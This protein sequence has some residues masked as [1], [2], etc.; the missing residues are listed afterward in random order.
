MGETPDFRAKRYIEIGGYSDLPTVAEDADFEETTS[1]TDHEATLQ[2]SKKG[3]IDRITR[4]MII[5][6]D[7][8]AVARIPK[9]MAAAAKRTLYKAV[10]N[11]IINNSNIYDGTPLYTLAHENLITDALNEDGVALGKARQKLKDMKEKDN[12]EKLGIRGKYLIIPSTQAMT[13]TAYKLTTGAFGSVNNIPKI[14]QTWGIEPIEVVTWNSQTNW[15]LMADPNEN[16]TVQ[17]DF[18]QG[19]QEPELFIQDQIT[20]D[21]FFVKER[22]RYKIRHEYGIAVLSFKT[23]VGAE[24][25]A[26]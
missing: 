12:A 9:K 22:I 24:V 13:E 18:L 8:N 4:A 14:F 23:S 17:V 5:N 6:D 25:P 15:R 10:F 7:L 21:T 11:P 1:P 19:K 20:S 26:P 2:A 3:Y 16:P